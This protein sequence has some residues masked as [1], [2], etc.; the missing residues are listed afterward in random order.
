M[1]TPLVRGAGNIFARSSFSLRLFQTCKQRII[2]VYHSVDQE[3]QKLAF[4]NTS[5]GYPSRPNHQLFVHIIKSDKRF[6]V[7][8]THGRERW[9]TLVFLAHDLPLWE[10]G[11]D[12]VKNPRALTLNRFYIQINFVHIRVMT[13]CSWADRRN[14][15]HGFPKG[16][17]QDRSPVPRLLRQ[18]SW[19]AFCSASHKT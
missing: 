2:V 19:L 14:G 17:V 5:K 13:A 18:N 3:A 7:R 4:V 15:I 12:P 8:V 10:R 1:F 16:P 6:I 11:M 9:L